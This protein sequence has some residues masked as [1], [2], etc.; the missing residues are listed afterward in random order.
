MMESSPEYPSSSEEMGMEIDLEAGSSESSPRVEQDDGANSCHRSENGQ[1]SR[2]SPTH[3]TGDEESDDS[4]QDIDHRHNTSASGSQHSSGASFPTDYG[5]HSDTSGGS[6]AD[7]ALNHGSVSHDDGDSKDYK[8]DHDAL[9]VSD[10]NVDSPQELGPSQ[11]SQE[12]R[13]SFEM[14]DTFLDN[15]CPPDN[16]SEEGEEEDRGIQKKEKAGDQQE[17]CRRDRI[18]KHTELGPESSPVPEHRES[19]YYIF[20]YVKC[21]ERQQNVMSLKVF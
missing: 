16:A 10:H 18:E 7:H 9:P 1:D 20:N 6:H 5:C 14:S 3:P 12:S 11:A 15:L 8:I 2:Y 21:L 19:C 13:G 4:F 17:N